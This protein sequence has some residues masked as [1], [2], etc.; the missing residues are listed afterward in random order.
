[1]KFNSIAIL[2]L[3]A[4]AVAQQNPPAAANACANSEQKQFDFWVGNWDV[5][6]PG[7]KQ[8]EVGRGTNSIRRIL[9]GCVVE[10]NFSGGDSM[11]LRGMSVS[12][13]DTRSGK[14]KQTWVDNE[15]G[16]L[17]FTGE[18]QNGQMI[19]SRSFT[20][21]DGTEVHQ[22]MVW[23]DISAD[24]LNWSWESSTDGGRTWEV[25]WP[26]HYQRSH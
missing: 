17:D 21:P 2:L 23:K 9:D 8:G 14:W 20:K 6:W 19:L 25:V 12:T 1:M 4:M 16:Y 15:G 3:G 26:I 18:M 10:E 24:Q 22:R 5:T 7:T 13:F 11:P